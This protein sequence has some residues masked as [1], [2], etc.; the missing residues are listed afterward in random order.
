MSFLTTNQAMIVASMT[1]AFLQ[2]TNPVKWLFYS[3]SAIFF[4]YL[5]YLTGVTINESFDTYSGRGKQVV[6]MLLA[7]FYI[8][9]IFFPVLFVVGPEGFQVSGE[10]VGL[11]SSGR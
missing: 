6:L 2:S 7:V 8:S 10:A 5:Y 11:P 4:I 3:I 1:S 9:W